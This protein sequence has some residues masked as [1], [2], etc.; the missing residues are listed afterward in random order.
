MRTCGSGSDIRLFAA[1]ANT[2]A[3]PR[4]FC[5]FARELS[6][7]WQTVSRRRVALATVPACPDRHARRPRATARDGLGLP[8]DLVPPRA[9]VRLASPRLRVH[10]AKPKVGL[11][12]TRADERWNIDTTVIR[13]LDGARPYLHAVIDN[14]SRR[15]LAWRVAD[16]FAP[17]NSVAVLLEASR[18]ATP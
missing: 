5:T 9:K 17:V 15:I 10:P 8:V 12:T 11:R 6:S 14:L 3:V 1:Q 18:G 16:T 2:R 4:T 13:L 7:R